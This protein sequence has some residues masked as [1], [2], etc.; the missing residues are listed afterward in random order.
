MP[1]PKRM[2]AAEKL[3]FMESLAQQRAMSG[4]APSPR[5]DVAL[6]SFGDTAPTPEEIESVANSLAT[7]GN[8]AD[9]LEFRAYA[10]TL[11]API[12]AQRDAAQ[13]QYDAGKPPLPVV[14]QALKSFKQAPTPEQVK[15]LGDYLRSTAGPE[16]AQQFETYAANMMPRPKPAQPTSVAP[17]LVEPRP[18]NRMENTL[19]GHIGRT[20]EGTR[21]MMDLP[22]SP[23]VVGPAPAPA[24]APAVQPVAQAEMAEPGLL[25]RAKDLLLGGR[26]INQEAIDRDVAALTRGSKDPGGFAPIRKKKGPEAKRD[27]NKERDLLNAAKEVPV[28]ERRGTTDSTPIDLDELRRDMFRNPHKYGQDGMGYYTDRKL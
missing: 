13:Q 14:D 23:G 3:V 7:S 22:P 8:P 2:T 4:V 18:K 15:T 12:Q 16:A 1:E 6:R 20:V 5:V 26:E 10:K 11:A 25:A 28:E 17:V 9:A 27:L 24:P 21:R 19:S